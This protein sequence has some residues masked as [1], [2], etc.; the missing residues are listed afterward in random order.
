MVRTIFQLKRPVRRDF[1]AMLYQLTEGNP[2]FVEEVLK[3][4]LAAGDIFFT[5]SIWDRKEL[6]ELHIPRSVYDSVQQRSDL[7][8]DAARETLAVAAVAGRDPGFAPLQALTGHPEHQVNPGTDTLIAAQ[9]LTETSPGA[10]DFCH[11]PP[12]Q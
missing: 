2:F 10:G 12:N 5:D 9:P 11:A 3:S 4:L 6:R 8:S 1:L 7:L